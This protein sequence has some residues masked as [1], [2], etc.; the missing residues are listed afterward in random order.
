[1]SDLLLY[2]KSDL[3]GATPPPFTLTASSGVEYTSVS[4]VYEVT[5]TGGSNGSW[6][7]QAY[8]QGAYTGGSSVS[9]TYPDEPANLEFARVSF[10]MSLDPTVSASFNTIDYG[11]IFGEYG[12][13]VHNLI[14]PVN[15][16]QDLTIPPEDISS[17]DIFTIV[18]AGR[19]TIWQ[20]NGAIVYRAFS[21][22]NQSFYFDSSFKHD[23]AVLKDVIFTALNTITLA[24]DLNVDDGLLKITLTHAEALQQRLSIKFKLFKGEYLFDTNAGIDYYSQLLKKGVSKEFLDNYFID[25]ILE[26]D[27]V[28]SLVSY[29][30]T[31][32]SGNRSYAVD[33]TVTAEDGSIVSVSL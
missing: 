8:S 14:N 16:P 7:E 3:Q 30:S 23:D 22:P 28:I 21:E 10:G 19:N 25:R 2:T 31:Y 29:T 24:G 5:K 20:H 26:T 32:D 12:A 27:G 18:Y 11:W 15:G 13:V 6:D 4:D 9:S 1:M 33:F 17:G